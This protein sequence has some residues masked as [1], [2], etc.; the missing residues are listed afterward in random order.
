MRLYTGFGF[1]RLRI[2]PVR[3]YAVLRVRC[4]RTADRHYSLFKYAARGCTTESSDKK[5]EIRKTLQIISLSQF[6]TDLSPIATKEKVV[7]FLTSVRTLEDFR[8]GVGMMSQLIAQNPTFGVN[9]D[10]S[11]LLHRLMEAAFHVCEIEVTW[12]TM[13]LFRE[14]GMQ[15]IRPHTYAML[16]LLRRNMEGRMEKDGRDPELILGTLEKLRTFLCYMEEDGIL[17]DYMLWTRVLVVVLHLVS[18]FDR[19][20]VYRERFSYASIKKREGLYIDFVITHKRIQDY[21]YAVRKVYQFL[22]ESLERI[23]QNILSR[24]NYAFMCRLAEIM[25]TCDDFDRMRSVLE[26][27]REMEMFFSDSLTSRLMQLAVGFN[28][29]D[30]LQVF[31]EWRIYHENSLINA[32]DCFRLLAYYCRSGGGKACPKCKDQYNHRN[33]SLDYWLNHVTP[34]QKAC[35]Y[36]QLART[37]KGAYNDLRDIPQNA[38]WSRQAFDILDFAISR[39]IEFNTGEWRLFLLCCTFSPNALKALH[40]MEKIYPL[41]M[42][43][44]IV[45]CTVCRLL[46]FNDPLQLLPLCQ[47]LKALG[48]FLHTMVLN[49]VLLGM[50]EIQDNEMRIENLETATKLMQATGSTPYMYTMEVLSLKITRLMEEKKATEDELSI[51]NELLLW[52]KRMGSKTRSSFWETF[53]GTTRKHRMYPLP[54]A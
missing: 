54:E 27:M 17:M 33:G 39:N 31:V 53:P 9:H 48:K 34:E 28:H 6:V 18:L 7:E 13:V 35:P 14:H 26:D 38:D 47:R 36:L 42:W 5:S 40:S 50:Y 25:F 16:N 41:S 20:L 51:V 15:L 2:L 4:E 24:P 43:D 8:R 44:D 23:R 30:A 19:Q 32:F 21:D 3:D 45:I 12:N 1:K 46:R 29:P 52:V 10:R 49:E 11:D 37:K 22:D